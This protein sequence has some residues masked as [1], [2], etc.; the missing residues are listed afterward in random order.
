V[1]R[2]GDLAQDLGRGPA[3]ARSIWLRYGFEIPAISEKEG[4]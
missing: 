1:R 2:L 3:Q 4:N